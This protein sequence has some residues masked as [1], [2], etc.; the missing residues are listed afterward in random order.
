MDVNKEVEDSTYSLPHGQHKIVCPMCK[1]ERKNKRDKALSVNI[2]N[3]RII[4]NCHHCGGKG[5]INKRRSFKMEVVK[6]EEKTAVEIPDTK[7]D[8][9]S[10]AWLEG[11]GI[12]K[13]TASDCG[14]VLGK[15][16]YKPVIGFTYPDERGGYRSNQVSKCKWREDFLVGG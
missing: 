9:E 8:E 2:D 14:V 12:S 5:V 15:K 4:Y 3:E 13:Q 10:I 6:K 1:N 16:K 11:R 7:Q